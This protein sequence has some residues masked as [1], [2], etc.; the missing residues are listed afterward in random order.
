[1]QSSLKHPQTDHVDL[2]QFHGASTPQQR[3]HVIKA[4][5]RMGCLNCN[6]A[7]KSVSSD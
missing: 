6:G 7:V 3:E 1:V 5:R 2:V 4:G